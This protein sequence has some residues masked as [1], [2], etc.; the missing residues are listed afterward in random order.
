MPIEEVGLGPPHDADE[1][2]VTFTGRL[3]HRYAP[4]ALAGTKLAVNR[5]A[6]AAGFRN[7]IRAGL[8]VVAPLYA[9]RT[10]VG[11]VPLDVPRDRQ[12]SFDPRLVPKGARR[13]DGLDEMIISLYA[14]GMT[15][16]D[17]GHH[18]ARTLSGYGRGPPR[19]WSSSR[20]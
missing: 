12:G 15:V 7:A 6:D 5:G 13:L 2:D 1:R 10:E 4:E 11:P 17:I 20:S 9:A 18:L 19:W 3:D 8:D 14:G 16:R